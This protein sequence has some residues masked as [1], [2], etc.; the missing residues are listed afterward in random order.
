[1]QKSLNRPVASF[2]AIITRG[3][4]GLQSRRRALV[5][6]GRVFRPSSWSVVSAAGGL[7]CA[8]L[9]TNKPANTRALRCCF[10]IQSPLCNVHWLSS[11]R[12]VPCA[13][14]VWES[15]PCFGR[16]KWFSILPY[17]GRGQGVKFLNC[18]STKNAYFWEIRTP[19]K[20]V[21][22]LANTF[23]DSLA[24]L[25]FFFGNFFFIGWFPVPFP[26]P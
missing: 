12:V 23:S 15:W 4:V 17:K 2:F 13:Q 22:I 10:P 8:Q 20:F 3:H 14:M 24:I 7:S 6:E 26:F 18:L 5:W 9:W 11:D 1:M 16:M 21:Q 19:K 25:I